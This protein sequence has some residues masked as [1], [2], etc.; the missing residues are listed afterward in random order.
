MINLIPINGVGCYIGL[1]DLPTLLTNKHLIFVC[2]SVH[3]SIEGL[4]QTA[5]GPD[6]YT[7]SWD[8]EDA[9][10]IL[11]FKIYNDGEF[12]GI[13]SNTNFTVG[14]LESCQ[15]YHAKVVA[16][17]GD[18]VVIN[19]KTATAHTGNA[20]SRDCS[21]DASDTVLLNKNRTIK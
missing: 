9:S 19:V 16:M 14:G 1:S 5:Y 18:D 6:N 4:C 20:Q 10:S 7:L 11:K 2:P 21:S 8:I 17:C 12:Y 13:T 15:Q 3:S